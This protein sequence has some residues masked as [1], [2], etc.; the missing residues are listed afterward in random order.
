MTSKKTSN[1]EAK[2]EER[3][4]RIEEKPAVCSKIY[5]R[6]FGINCLSERIHFCSHTGRQQYD[7]NSGKTDSFTYEGCAACPAI[8]YY[9]DGARRVSL[10]QGN[11]D[12]DI[13][14]KC[15]GYNVEHLNFIQELIVYSLEIEKKFL[16]KFNGKM[17][18]QKKKKGGGD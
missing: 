17:P 14:K 11:Y 4:E 18:F 7:T 12:P 1:L 5:Y 8:I 13:A 6:S 10:G 9:G 15:P 3:E 2:A 16:T